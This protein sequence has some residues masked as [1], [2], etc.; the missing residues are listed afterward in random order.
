MTFHAALAVMAATAVPVAMRTS[1]PRNLISQ[2][3]P[4]RSARLA[5]TASAHLSSLRSGNSK[6][7]FARAY[8]G[9]EV[10]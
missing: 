7:V 6:P 1:L 5:R 9:K 8:N 10:R 3:H 4:D 2:L